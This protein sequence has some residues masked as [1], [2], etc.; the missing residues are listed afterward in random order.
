MGSLAKLDQQAITGVVGPQQ[1]E[2]LIR[3]VWATI[4]ANVPAMTLAHRLIKTVVL[5]PVGWLLIAPLFGLRLLGFL[6]GLSF[7][8]HKY[9]I[10]NRRVMVRHGLKPKP[11]KEI[12]LNEI[13]DVRVVPD[14]NSEFYVTGKLEILHHDGSV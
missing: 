5:A 7:L 1:G 10:T 12:P 14:A 9:T 11:V 6:P 13:G 8:T 4:A 2:A 3:E